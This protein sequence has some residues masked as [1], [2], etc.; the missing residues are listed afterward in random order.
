MLRTKSRQFIGLAIVAGLL[1]ASGWIISCGGNNAPI[2]VS[3]PTTGVITTSLT[4]PPVC[5]SSF[6]HV[7]VTITKVTA[8][9]SST[10]SD[11]DSGWVTLVDLT[12][13][14]K[15]IDLLS[16]ASTT[17]LLAQLGSTSGLPP[18]NYQQIRL[19]L[20]AND[21]SSGPSPNACGSGNGF[22]CVVPSGDTPQELLLSSEAK[23]GIKIPPGQIAGGGINLVAGQAADLNI[24][25]DGCHSIIR[26]GNGA[27]RLLPTLHAGEV[28]VNNNAL[29]GKVVDSSNSNPIPGAVVLLEQP[30][31]SAIDR[32]MDAGVTDAN[33]MFNFCPL[34]PGNYDVVV[35]ATVTVALTTTVYG[36]TI[37]FNV[38]TGTALNSIPLVSEGTG[39]ALTTPWSTVSG[40]VTSAGSS[41]ATVADITFSALQDATPSGGTLT[42]V[43]IPIFG[44]AAQPPV[45]ETTPTPTP[46]TPAC[47]LATDCFNY[48]ETIPSGNPSVGTFSGGS[49]GSFGAP[50]TGSVNYSLLFESTDCTA[51]TPSPALLTSITVTPAGKTT[52]T[53][54]PAFTGCTAP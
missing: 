31:S 46:S 28:S 26:E 50:A 35:D 32:I 3:N 49:M 12:T 36:A 47:P 45:F 41:G 21:A 5:A 37:A 52:A 2:P 17:C 54:T 18:G 14:P 23:T 7:W 22:N 48:S 44:V 15:Q 27:Y 19:L 16:L 53:V 4:D 6:D 11:T 1:I 51:S 29:S 9:I 39:T 24:N 42:H 38:P 43:T 13:A 10:A 34:P 20:L 8:N 40:Q 33:G 25:F 30:D